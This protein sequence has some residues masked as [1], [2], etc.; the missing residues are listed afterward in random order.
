MSFLRI[1][2]SVTYH[3]DLKG[4][5]NELRQ[6][7]IKEI[8]P[9]VREQSYNMIKIIKRKYFSGE[10]YLRM[11]SGN[12]KRS[13]VKALEQVQMYMGYLMVTGGVVIGGSVPYSGV[14][15]RENNTDTSKFTIKSGK[16]KN[17]LTVPVK[18]GPADMKR[19]RKRTTSFNN[20]IPIFPKN[21]NPFLAIKRRDGK[22]EPVY[23]LKKKVQ[24]PPR[25]FVDD[26]AGEYEPVFF[27][28]IKQ[29]VDNFIKSNK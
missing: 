26:M 9:V 24:V 21:K 15:I 27:E 18:D 29:A 7:L 14:H 5:G 17:W 2:V 19:T 20:L 1:P 11:R 22:L 4:F 6:S 16:N 10:P 8:K 28:A 25:V 13:I 3:K 12:L 23:W